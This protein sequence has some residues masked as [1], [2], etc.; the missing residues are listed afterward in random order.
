MVHG[1]QSARTY[2]NASQVEVTTFE[3][4]ALF[5][6]HDLNRGTSTFF[7]TPKPDSTPTPTAEPEASPTAA[8]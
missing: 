4:D 7:K 3:V 8:A 6:G 1:K 5:V 2:V